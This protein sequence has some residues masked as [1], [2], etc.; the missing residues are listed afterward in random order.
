[1]FKKAGQPNPGNKVVQ[2]PDGGPKIHAS[3]RTDAGSHRLAQKTAAIVLAGGKGARLGAL[4]VDE[5][6]P[7]LPFGG[8]YRNI[9]FSLSNCVNSEIYRIGVAT[10]YKDS[11]LLRHLEQVW[12]DTS[13]PG[14]GF[15]QP[16]RAE[17]NAGGGSYLGT[18]D[19][20]YQNWSRIDSLDT[21]W[22]LILAGDHVY[23]MDYRQLLQRQVDNQADITVGCVEV[24][25]QEASHFGVM[26]VDNTDRIVRFTEKPTHPEELDGR[27]GRAL[28]SMGIYVFN[29][30]LLGDL[31]QE[32]ALA[33]TSSHDFG[34]DLLPR[35]INRAKVFA[36]RFTQDA[37]I[38]GGYWRDVGTIPA[39]WRAHMEFLDGIAGYSPTDTSWPIRT[40]RR[41]QSVTESSKKN[42]HQA[43][44]EA[45]SLLAEGCVLDRAKVRRSVLFENVSVAAHTELANTVILPGAVIG[46]HCQLSDVIVASGVHVPDGTIVAPSRQVGSSVAAV[47]MPTLI[48]ADTVRSGDFGRPKQR[49][50]TGNLSATTGYRNKRLIDYKPGAWS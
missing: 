16:W 40:D 13:L 24:P 19:A 5:C 50:T 45:G 9:D 14:A 46:R 26:S 20:V 47:G 43:G 8:L 22:V 4:T 3:G 29:R 28:G 10:Q 35:L 31:L 18:A 12:P 17:L 39:Y 36:Y 6:K 49:H 42:L 15:I 25:I 11:S 32:D 37:A 27:P 2:L 34:R 1:M 23:K 48:S 30:K 21:Q 38:G 41:L 33:D 44:R 7:A